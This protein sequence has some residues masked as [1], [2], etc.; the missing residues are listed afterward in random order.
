MWSSDCSVLQ[1]NIG[2][3]VCGCGLQVAVVD[4]DAETVW[5]IVGD[6]AEGGAD[7]D[8]LGGGLGGDAAVDGL[9]GPLGSPGGGGDV[10][11]ALQV[12][13]VVFV[14]WALQGVQVMWVM[15]P[16]VSAVVVVVLQTGVDQVVV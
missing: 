1:D 11:R 5:L 12:A 4:S 3:A 13:L 6:L 7:V 14:S 2:G 9:L 10:P 8:G 15:L 16:M